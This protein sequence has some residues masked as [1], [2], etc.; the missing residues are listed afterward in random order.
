TSSEA[1]NIIGTLSMNAV[2]AAGLSLAPASSTIGAAV[3][4]YGF[5]LNAYLQDVAYTIHAVDFGIQNAPGVRDFIGELLVGAE[6]IKPFLNRL[7]LIQPADFEDLI[8]RAREELML[9]DA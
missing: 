3:R 8:R 9:H 2:R 1:F 6:N 7:G 5:L 4:L